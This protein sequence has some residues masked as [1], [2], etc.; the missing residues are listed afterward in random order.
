MRE[1]Y[2]DN[3]KDFINR[4]VI[5]YADLV[6]LLLAL[7]LVMYA[8]NNT[9]EALIKNEHNLNNNVYKENIVKMPKIQNELLREFKEDNN[10]IL[11]KDNR[12]LIIRL[13]DDILFGSA[14]TT[15]RPEFCKTLDR[16]ID[17]LSKNDNPVIIE[18]HTDSFPIFSNKYSSN[19]EL[20]TARATSVIN[21]IVKTHRINPKR[22][23]AVGYG[24]NIPIAENTSNSGRIK[25]R[26]VDIIILSK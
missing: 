4:W 21:Y 9:K 2:Y 3:S 13:S 14:D 18:G 10:V 17:I 20:S 22:L 25:N 26:R 12:G 7:F 1:R 15:I 19:W 23:S 5:S 8:L 24:D 16:I 11:L 6:T